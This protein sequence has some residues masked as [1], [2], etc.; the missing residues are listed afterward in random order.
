MSANSTPFCSPATAELMKSVGLLI[1]APISQIPV[2][3]RINVAEV[4][5][6]IVRARN[7]ARCGPILM[8]GAV[9]VDW[10]MWLL[11]TGCRHGAG[12]RAIGGGQV[13]RAGKRI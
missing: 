7:A 9:V 1:S 8:R 4:R 13:G 11:G 6:R 10:V 12:M 2:P 5:N 3:A